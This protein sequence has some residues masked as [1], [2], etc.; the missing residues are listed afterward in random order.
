MLLLAVASVPSASAA[1]YLQNLTPRLELVASGFSLPTQVTSAG[2]GSGR[3]F[4][5][6]QAGRIRVLRGGRVLATPLLDIQA[7]VGSSELEQGL[8]GLA[9]H[10]RFRDNG[11]FYVNYT[12]RNGDTV[13]ARY[14][15]SD[16]SDMA[17]PGTE[18]VMLRI[19][20][21]AA[22]HNGGFLLF[23]PDGYLWIGTGD[24]G[25]AGAVFPRAQDRSLLLGKMLRVDVQGAVQY[26]I[27]P[28][29][30]FLG[31]PDAAPEIWAY[32]LRNP[33]RYTF[34][35]ATGDLYIADVGQ[36]R[37][38]WVHFVPVGSPGGMNFGWPIVEGLHCQPEQVSCDQSSVWQPVA[39]YDHT[40]GCAIV[41]G[42]VYRGPAYP[43]AQGLYLFGDY[44]SGRIWSLSR[45]ADGGWINEELLS[46]GPS[47]SSFGEDDSGELYLTAIHEG[48]LY[49]L[50]W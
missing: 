25:G 48:T 37:Y 19:P 5:L 7:R 35:R 45:G 38:E 50:V 27:P 21:P 31:I 18:A 13:V 33:W 3:L 1:P 30:S 28:N 16:G 4:V 15:A 44:C 32:G 14:S 17:D 43:Q 11:W 26:A 34:D 29:N 20:Q 2:D 40:L 10:P 49:R 42:F 9:F 6:E 41:G 46:S 22:N 24:G 47:I 39:E 36:D 8:L 23:G 12:D